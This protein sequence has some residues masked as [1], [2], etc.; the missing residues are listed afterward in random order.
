MDITTE[1]PG[2]LDESLVLKKRFSQLKVNKG[3]E[4]TVEI[5]CLDEEDV[6][7][8]VLS[9]EQ[10]RVFIEFLQKQLIK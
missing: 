7:S 5:T 8:F 6:E 9:Q 2:T 10:L 4:N 1:N 3:F